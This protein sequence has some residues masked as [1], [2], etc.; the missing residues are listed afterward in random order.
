[1]AVILQYTNNNLK[2]LSEIYISVTES[3]DHNDVD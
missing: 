3:S 2:V 1:M